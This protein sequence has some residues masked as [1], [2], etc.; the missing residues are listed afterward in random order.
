MKIMRF[1]FYSLA[2]LTL[3]NLAEVQNVN[4]QNILVGWATE[5]ITPEGPVSLQGQ[6]YERISEYVQSP[7][8]VTAL[9]I[10]SAGRGDT[11]QAIMISVDVVNFKD[12]LQDSLR[13]K[14]DGKIPG[15]NL[16]KLFLNATHTH[17]SFNTGIKSKEREMLLDK[18][19]KVLCFS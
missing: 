17:S 13:K 3:L 1:L 6:Y 9:A 12:G 4:A 16:Q 2:V 14:L 18:L 8:M 11:E 15:F 10:E 19:S 5:D 7:L